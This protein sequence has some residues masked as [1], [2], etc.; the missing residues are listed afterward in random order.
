MCLVQ[1]TPDLRLKAWTLG[2]ASKLG[3]IEQWYEHG[4]APDPKAAKKEARR[5]ELLRRKTGVAPGGLDSCRPHGSILVT[6]HC[7]FRDLWRNGQLDS[8]GGGGD[9]PAGER[10][11]L[12]RVTEGAGLVIMDEAHCIR[13]QKINVRP[14]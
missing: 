13:N 1:E 14:S 7:G 4:A 2:G 9:A 5:E 11:A 3:P 12:Q 6:T 8:G 10:L